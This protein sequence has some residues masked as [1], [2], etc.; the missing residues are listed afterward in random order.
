[1]SLAVQQQR[2]FEKKVCVFHQL[3]HATE[4]AKNKA[5]NMTKGLSAWKQPPSGIISSQQNGGYKQAL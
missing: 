5:L 4:T 1:M 2:S 3:L